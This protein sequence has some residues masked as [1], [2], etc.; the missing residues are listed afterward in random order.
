[1]PNV[2][3]LIPRDP[4]IRVVRDGE[5]DPEGRCV[6]HWM[7]RCQRGTDNAALDLAIDLANRLRLPVVSVF[8]LTADYPG[9]NLRH[10]RFLADGL[11]ETRDELERRGVPMLVRIGQP[12]QVVL[13]ASNEMRP[14]LVVGDENPVRIGQA[15]RS[16]LARSLAVPFTCVDSDVVVPTSLFPREEYAARTIRPK[17]HKV[18]HQYLKSSMNPRVEFPWNRSDVPRGERLDPGV[19]LERLGV[20]GVAEVKGYRGGPTEAGRRLE[21]F[22]NERLPRYATERNEPSPS[23]TSELSAHL[24]FGQIGPVTIALRVLESGAPRESIDAY[25]EELIV[26]RE[27]AINFVARNPDYDR[28][29]GCPAWA[30]ATL[31]KHE[32][33]PRPVLYTPDQLE[34]SETHDP[35]WNAAQTEMV[36]TGRMHNSLRMYWAKKI[37][38]WSPDAATAFDVAIRL[39]DTYEL[40]GRDPNGYAGVAWAIGG[41]HDRPWPERP[42]FGT[43]RTMTYD[44]IRRKLDA[45]AYLARIRAIEAGTLPAAGE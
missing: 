27:L 30:R 5:T 3:S 6:F 15:W 4:R 20:G 39:N 44:G 40:D 16:S 2:S 13:A 38:E 22:V 7:Q 8:G 34:A 18:W 32:T 11:A 37:L 29:E 41:K 35:I 1:M 26:R 42:I 17:I 28:I 14:A 45:D 43:V 10:Y 23:M 12:H 25:L 33:D 31:K 36:L 9:A 24:H 21:R 19:L